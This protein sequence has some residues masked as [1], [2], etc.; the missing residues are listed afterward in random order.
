MDVAACPFIPWFGEVWRAHHYS[1]PGDS[2]GGSRLFSG[3][4]NRGIDLYPDDPDWERCRTAGYVWE[5]LYLGLSWGVCLAEVT[6]HLT[7]ETLRAKQ[8]STRFS[9]LRVVLSAV[10]DCT[11][12]ACAGVEEDNLFA[13]TY[14][15]SHALARAARAIG[16]EALLLPSACRMPGE[17]AHVLVIFPDMLHHDSIIRVVLTTTP[18]LGG[19]R[20]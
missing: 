3:R 20:A 17:D 7:P 5:A 1:Y 12:L 8:Q 4:Y 11:N 2:T 13:D 14:E 10:L 15:T 6:R 9:Q 18:N 19:D 16:A